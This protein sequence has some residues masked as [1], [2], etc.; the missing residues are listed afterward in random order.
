[1]HIWIYHSFWSLGGTTTS[2]SS[3]RFS[4][5]RLLL[6]SSSPA[7]G[8]ESVRGSSR[9]VSVYLRSVCMYVCMFVCVVF[10]YMDQYKS[11]ST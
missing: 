7:H 4:W 5:M 6:L 11:G 1:M 9:C 10:E 3:S 2:S 8:G